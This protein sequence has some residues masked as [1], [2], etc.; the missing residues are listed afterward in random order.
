MSN[1]KKEENPNLEYFQFCKDENLPIFISYDN[2]HYSEKLEN[3]LIDLNF[4]K[5]DLKEKPEEQIKN[6]VLTKMG[7]ILSV[8]L[9]TP[10]LYDAMG[11]K[12]S[13]DGVSSESATIGNNAKIYSYQG[14]A[15][16]VYS[17]A[18][19]EWEIA[20]KH[21]FGNNSNKVIEKI[22]INRFLSLSL[23]NLGIIGFWGK[24]TTDG[25]LLLNQF[26]SNGEAIYFNV[27]KSK[28]IS[29]NQRKKINGAFNFYKKGNK[30]QGQK[31][32]L[33]REETVGFLGNRC[34]FLDY[35]GLTLPVRQ[36]ISTLGRM[37]KCHSQ[38]I[39]SISLID[40]KSSS[41]SI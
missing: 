14:H 20:L 23:S 38:S 10:S 26:E 34:C 36:M 15:I 28:I 16:M 41:L 19:R 9:P 12:Y 8:R 35:P 33:S 32:T 17:L 13:E 7:T 24:L 1:A 29:V 2:T 3:F 22:I 21:D 5:V 31:I 4:H 11:R 27:L 6:L 39:S 40:N 30:V 18:S 37:Y 25:A